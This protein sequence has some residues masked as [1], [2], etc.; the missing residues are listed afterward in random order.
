MFS[1]LQQLQSIIGIFFILMG[2]V[3]VGQHLLAAEN[4]S[5]LNIYTGIGFLIFGGA[6][7]GFSK[8]EE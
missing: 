3:L 8:G 4:S 1:K 6:M 5:N 2:I 7:L